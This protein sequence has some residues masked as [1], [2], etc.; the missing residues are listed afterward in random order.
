LYL[1]HVL[2]EVNH[3]KDY[4]IE[5]LI[6]C[7]DA[8]YSGARLQAVRLLSEWNI[9]NIN[10]KLLSM[11]VSETDAR[12]Y[13]EIAIALSRIGETRAIPQIRDKIFNND[14]IHID[15]VHALGMFHSEQA[16]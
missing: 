13:S 15:T 16:I 8:E 1:E 7:L 2:T 14:T 6:E 10:D 5:G 9:P 4:A 3:L 12:T 11:L